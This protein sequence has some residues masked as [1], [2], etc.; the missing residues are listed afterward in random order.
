MCPDTDPTGSLAGRE[1]RPTDLAEVLRRLDL[2]DRKVDWI[3]RRVSL[4]AMRAASPSVAPAHERYMPKPAAA[5]QPSAASD[6]STTPAAQQ[7][8]VAP[9]HDRYMPKPAAAQQPSAA[10]DASTTL[11]PEAPRLSA[12][13]EPTTAAVADPFTPKAHAPVTDPFDPKAQAPWADPFAAPRTPAPAADPFAAAPPR[14]PGQPPQ[15]EP[16]TPTWWERSRSEGN[17]GRYLLSGAAA[18][19]VLLAAI[20]LIAL[21]W[22]S[23]PD[24]LKVLALGVV[25][26]ALVVGGT[27]LGE[28]RP[29]QAVAAATL[30]GTGGALGY[31]AVVGA[32]LLDVG[33]PTPGAFGLMAVWGVLLLV[34][35]RTSAQ[36]FASVI[37]ALGGLVTVGFSAH[38]VASGAA[39]VVTTWLMVDLLI[40][41]LAA[42]CGV[43]MRAGG[44]PATFIRPAAPVAFGAVL[45]TPQQ[46]MSAVSPLI[47]ILLMLVPVLVLYAEVIDEPFAPG[48]WRLPAGLGVSAAGAATIITAGLT[49]SMRGTQWYSQDGDTIG[50][51]AV[52]IVAAAVSAVLLV[53]PV[54]NERWRRFSVIAHLVVTVLLSV[55]AEITAPVLAPL[56]MLTLAAACLLAV[57]ES[58]A[59]AVLLPAVTVSLIV[60]ISLGMSSIER[61]CSLVA[62]LGS[63][64]V[65][66]LLEA[67]LATVKVRVPTTPPVVPLEGPHPAAVALPSPEELAVA[68]RRQ[69]LVCATWVL[70]VVLVAMVPFLIGGWLDGGAAHSVPSL[71]GGALA[72]TLT[73]AGLFQRSATPLELVRGQALR[74]P[75]DASAEPTTLAWLGLVILGLASLLQLLRTVGTAGFAWDAAHVVV[76]LAIAMAGVRC[77][78]TWLRQTDVLLTSVLLLSAVTW[79]SVLILA[80]TGVNSV[81]MTIMILATGA[82]CITIGF[83]VRLTMLRHYGL[84]LVLVS[85]L[86]LAL[87]DIGDQSSITRV[88]A[89]LVAGLVCFGLSLAYNKIANDA[90]ADEAGY[91]GPAPVQPAVP[92]QYGQV[93]PQT[94]SPAPYGTSPAPYGQTQAP[95]QPQG[96]DSPPSGPQAS[97]YGISPD[98]GRWQ[99]PQS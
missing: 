53:L 8:S 56:V 73:L 61:G 48:R 71:L 30:A 89:L 54:P 77:V 99:P 66:P 29:R 97:S 3:A 35:S 96:P 2:L 49:T 34:V 87:L 38:Q 91:G 5:Q 44:Q 31:V 76:A 57:T 6:A 47:G 20:T 90:K 37:S 27:M 88:L 45:M 92:A 78:R 81:L 69:V 51:T 62:V 19:L 26:L 17:I 10:S 15:T 65:A 68:Q 63:V 60:P 24:L 86:K 40:V 55:A 82:T 80:D 50:L 79:A 43:L 72:V 25:S 7:P 64:A 36:G 58:V 32:V 1:E 93:Q 39:D 98:P 74:D 22:D 13:A 21:V 14:Y 46:A 95:W 52:L 75:A 42:S 84:V 41:I 33:L 12:G 9:A 11:E 67:R 83:R 4:G 59:V 18:L 16:H 70:T 23:I 85:V 28:S 94:P